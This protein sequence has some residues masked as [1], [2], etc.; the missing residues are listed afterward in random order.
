MDV[1]NF[2]N[3]VFNFVSAWNKKRDVTPSEQATFIHL[4]EEV[5][6]LAREYVNQE[7]RKNKFSGEELNNAIGDALIQLIKLAHLRNL[8]IETLILKIIEDEQ[9]LLRSGDN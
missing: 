6:E 2:Q 8:D 4:V 1:K 9:R 5:G 3:E 7:S